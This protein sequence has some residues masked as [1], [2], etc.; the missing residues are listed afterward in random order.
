MTPPS[1]S[2]WWG[3]RAD[4]TSQVQRAQSEIELAKANFIKSSTV[5]A[6][7]ADLSDRLFLHRAQN[8]FAHRLETLY[9]ELR[10]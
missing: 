6:S 8:N 4:T 3:R 10:R 7:A 9:L 5:A 1:K 2:R